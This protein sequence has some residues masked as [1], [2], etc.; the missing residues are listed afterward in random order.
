RKGI[1]Q[2]QQNSDLT[3]LGVDQ[4]VATATRLRGNNYWRVHASDL[5]RAFRTAE[6]ILEEHEGPTP[7]KSELLRE[8]RLG[9]QEGLPRGTTWL[10]LACRIKAEKDG[11]PLEDFKPPRRETAA[12]VRKRS[13]AFL[14]ELIAD[15][16]QDAPGRDKEEMVA[17]VVSHGGLLNVMMVGVM[18]LGEGVGFMTNCGVTIV[19]V[20]KEDGGDTSVS[21]EAQTVNDD[22]HL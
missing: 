12:E 22:K 20:F 15:A 4:A 6:I 17:L 16:A 2:G 9:V 19:K 18:G 10:V 11:V 7:K 5:S 21:Y 8:F 1:I 13:E 14:E 3:P